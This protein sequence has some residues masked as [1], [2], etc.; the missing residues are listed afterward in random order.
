MAVTVR[1][2]DLGAAVSEIKIVRWLA[3]AGDKVSRGALLVELETDKAA[4]ELESIADG[5]LLK[6]CAAA[7]EVVEPGAVIAYIGEPGEALPGEAV[8]TPTPAV[9]P[10]IANLAR[11]L[12]VDLALVRGTGACG[13]ITREDVLAVGRTGPP[14]T[15]EPSRTQDAV[16]RAVTKSSAEI[17]HLRVAVSLD[18]SAAREYRG[19]HRAGYEAILLK[20]MAQA[21]ESAPIVTCRLEGERVVAPTGVH[22]GL[23]VSFDNE[24][25]MPVLRDVGHKTAEQLQAEVEAV[26]ARARQRTLTPEEL[27]GGSMAL[28]NLGM[29]AIDWFDAIIFPGHSLIVALAAAA[30]RAVAVNGGVEVRPIATVTIA[31]D[32]RLINGR[33]AAE[34]ATKLKEIVESGAFA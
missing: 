28:S 5:V 6:Q 27:T 3:E 19:S 33:A 2:P 9:A 29:Y 26:S 11:K 24:L 4:M 7:G 23:A 14:R 8:R 16:A 32:H 1:M 30:D 31:A 34:F 17:P 18:M 13:A 22:I 21:A 15:A 10:V 20:A 12:G 25:F